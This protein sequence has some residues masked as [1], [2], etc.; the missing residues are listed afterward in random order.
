MV[1]TLH[2][3]TQERGQRQ[4]LIPLLLRATEVAALLSLSKS[5][6]HEMMQTGELP[7]I[8]TGRSVRVQ[9]SALD[10]WITD[11]TT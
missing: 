1:T 6:V 11:H 2:A 9:R 3:V 4:S 10:Q 5:K 7:C 8:R